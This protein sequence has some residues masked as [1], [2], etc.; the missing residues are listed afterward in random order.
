METLAQS[1]QEKVALRFLERSDVQ[2]ALPQ[3]RQSPDTQAALSR[4][5]A[6]ALTLPNAERQVQTQVTTPEAAV[7]LAQAVNETS[8]GHPSFQVLQATYQ[9][10]MNT[11]PSAQTFAKPSV[12]TLLTNLLQSPQGDASS[13]KSNVLQLLALPE[14][15]TVCVADFPK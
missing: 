9:I 13:E 5:L 2:S 15:A 1:G 6:Q 10:L 4:V 3:I 7:S 8:G 11:Q 14:M 12:Q